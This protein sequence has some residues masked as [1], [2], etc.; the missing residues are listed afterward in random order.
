MATDAAAPPRTALPGAVSRA[1]APASRRA[2]GRP[3]RGLHARA[4]GAAHA[5]ALRRARLPLLL[6]RDLTRAARGR[7]GRAGRLPPRKLVRGRPRGPAR[8]L[9]RGARGAARADAAR[10]RPARLLERHRRR[11]SA[12]TSCS[13]SRCVCVLAAVPFVA[14]GRHDRPRGP[15]LRELDR[16]RVR[17]R[18]RRR[19]ARRDRRRAAAVGGLRHTLLVGLSR[20]SPRSPPSCSRSGPRERRWPPERRRSPRWRP[21][22]PPPP[23]S[24]SCRRTPPRRRA[25]PIAVHWTPLTRVLAYPP[26]GDAKIAPL[27]YDRIYAPVPVRR[28]GDPI[29]TG[30]SS[31]SARRRS[32]TS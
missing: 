10:A 3:G 12:P 29:P 21:C 7:G 6:P 16:P 13:R 4:P 24:T 23:T 26:P 30:G 19:R 9:G 8:A 1:P 2:R 28:P 20:S 14:A 11:R 25:S 17:L 32:A 18:P 27:F 15:G 22:S 5:R 31:R